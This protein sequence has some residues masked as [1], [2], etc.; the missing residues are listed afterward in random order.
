MQW[1]SLKASE[2]Q[3]LSARNAIV[4][5]PVASLENHG[6]HL[7]TGTDIVLSSEIATRAAAR[8]KGAAPVIVMPT[9]W[10]ALGAMH[11]NLGG[12]VTLDLETLTAVLRCLCRSVVK[13]GFRRVFLLNGHGGNIGAL[14]A[15]T[16]ELGAELDIAIATATYWQLAKDEFAAILEDQTGLEHACEGETSMMMALAP[17]HVDPSKFSQA[18]GPTSR[19]SQEVAGLA[20][21]PLAH[22]RRAHQPWRARQSDTV[23]RR[24]G[25][26]APGSGGQR[27]RQ[28]ARQRRILDHDLLTP[29]TSTHHLAGRRRDDLD[30]RR[31]QASQIVGFT[32]QHRARR[33]RRRMTAVVA[34]DAAV[35][36]PR[37]SSAM[38]APR[39]SIV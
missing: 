28:P 16:N 20:V 34:R 33:R 12:T 5:I 39:G 32:G 15:I 6:P 24:E 35:A 2:I 4:V 9:V 30:G 31:H 27:R 29:A 36:T 17:D 22:V 25:R 3:A 19:T 7:A 1:A 37:N 23:E 21:H 13:Q 11:M 38:A 26:K 14:M 8:T 10:C 18:I